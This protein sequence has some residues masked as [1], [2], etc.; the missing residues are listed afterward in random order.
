[1]SDGFTG[2]ALALMAAWLAAGVETGSAR[3]SICVPAPNAGKAKGYLTP[4]HKE[5][6]MSAMQA[7]VR[8][9]KHLLALKEEL[10]ENTNLNEA[11]RLV[12]GMRFNKY[13][14]NVCAVHYTNIKHEDTS[15]DADDP[16]RFPYNKIVND[17]C[18]QYHI[19]DGS[20][21]Q[22]LNAKLA[23]AS[24]LLHFDI[25]VK[26][27]KP[28]LFFYGKFIV[29]NIDNEIDFCF[30]FYR[31]DFEIA[32]DVIETRYAKK[33]LLWTISERV[34]TS[35]KDVI[36]NEKDIEH[37]N[38]Y[39]RSKLFEKLGSEIRGLATCEPPDV[40]DSEPASRRRRMDAGSA[41]VQ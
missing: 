10:K 6:F 18:K 40:L 2:C 17:L 7:P 20:K 32:P 29:V 25:K 36:L 33:F 38:N 41:S 24:M 35:T 28:G 14:E 15:K 26:P 31:L 3:S 23:E 39:F 27:G 12:K 8:L 37:F 5:P 22:L 30:M 9:F 11:E 4:V 34:E 13:Q 21:Q 1:M 19:E 16:E